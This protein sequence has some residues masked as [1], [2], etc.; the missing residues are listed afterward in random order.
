VAGFNRIQWQLSIGM[1]GNLQLESVAGFNRNQWQLSRGI[2]NGI[3][4]LK[5]YRFTRFKLIIKETFGN[6]KPLLTLVLMVALL[7]GRRLVGEMRM[8]PS[9]DQCI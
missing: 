8:V 4:F 1:G 3:Q 2:R 5:N 7:L 9:Q 6:I